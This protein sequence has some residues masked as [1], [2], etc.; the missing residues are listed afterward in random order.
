MDVEIS[1]EVNGSTARSISGRL[2][3]LRN[4]TTPITRLNISAT[5]ENPTCPYQAGGAYSHSGISFLVIRSSSRRVV[6][7]KNG[8]IVKTLYEY[9]IEAEI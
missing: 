7:E 5:G 1:S 3:L 4:S 2:I 8:I 9:A 6:S